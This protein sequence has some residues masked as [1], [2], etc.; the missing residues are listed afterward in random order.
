[1]S[2]LNTINYPADLKQLSLDELEL[3]AQEIRD[4][5]ITTTSNNGGHLASNLGVVE[6]TIALHYVFD[7]PS[8]KLVWD[9]SHQTYTHKILT[10]RKDFF[11]SLRTFKGCSGF[12]TREE[13]GYDCFGAGHAGTSIS[14]ALG[15]AAGRDKNKTDEKIVAILGDGS[16]TNGVVLEGL[17]NIAHVTNDLV[18]ILND[19]KMSISENVGGFRYYL[20]DIIQRKGYNRFRNSIKNSLDKIPNIGSKIHSVISKIEEA[21]KSIIVPGVIFEQMGM[22]YIGP[23]DGHDIKN[24]VKTFTSIKDFKKPVIIHTL[25]EKGRGYKPAELRPDKYHGV[26]KFDK[27][28]GKS[29]KNNSQKTFSETFGKSIVR[30]A[31]KHE[32]VVGITAAMCAG[33]SLSEFAEKYS[34][35]FFDVGIAEEHAV[36]FAAGM[37]TNGLRPVFAVYSTFLQRALACV[38]HDICIQNL[39]VI[40]CTDRSG[41]V[42]D[43]PTHHGIY[44]ISYLKS[45][46]N[47]SILLPSNDKELDVMLNLAYD[48]KS[49]VI[50]RY[51]KASVPEHN[52]VSS[53]IIW[54]KAN[55]IKKGKDLSIWATG[56]ECQTA[57]AV[58]EIL[59]ERG[60]NA[61]VTNALFLK[62][63]DDKLL[64]EKAKKMPI[65]TIEDNCK[66]GGLAS[67]VDEILINVKH[68]KILHFGWSNDIIPHGSPKKIR[69]SLGFTAVDIAKTITADIN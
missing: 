17:N 55:I 13:S 65:I 3:L 24:L 68:K 54:G 11:N 51:P 47:L 19:N 1:M 48:S 50:I 58:A 57:V 34:D 14:A 56:N 38:Y 2:I 49:P 18:I 15:M 28:T 31:D 10:G 27:K 39:P 43:G 5:I 32:D 62:P 26:G 8:D 61:E 35:R 42:E 33:T 37:A 66:S 69:E 6:L 4:K 52:Y 53:N 41:I 44:S 63:F 46:P 60:M 64:I 25:T 22:R 29:L 16:L 45:L 40:I 20:N 9:V 30:L 36:V 67:I 7:T 12:T 23:V 21:T 59:L